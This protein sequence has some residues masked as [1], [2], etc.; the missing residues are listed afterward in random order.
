MIHLSKNNTRPVLP[1][2]LKKPL[3]DQIDTDTKET[4]NKLAS[5]LFMVRHGKCE[6]ITEQDVLQAITLCKLRAK[7]TH[8]TLNFENL[9]SVKESEL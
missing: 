8:E 1:N 5:L 6:P 7:Q 4:V 9:S 2:P 3:H